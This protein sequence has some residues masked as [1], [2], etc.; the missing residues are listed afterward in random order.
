MSL[1]LANDGRLS[2]IPQEYALVLT[3]GAKL[4]IVVRSTDHD[5]FQSLPVHCYIMHIISMHA[6]VLVH[7][8]CT[9][10]ALE[11]ILVRIPQPNDL[12]LSAGHTVRPL[13]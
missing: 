5:S 9:I 11:S 7:Q 1:K 8:K 10:P 4:G 2:H 6:L 13:L 12:V 3:T